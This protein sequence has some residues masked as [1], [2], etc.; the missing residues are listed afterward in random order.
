MSAKYFCDVCEAQMA[1]SDM[2]RI[3]RKLGDVEIEI[4]TAYRGCWNN[5]HLCPACILKAVTDGEPSKGL[6]E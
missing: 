6:T 4:M 3:K 5:G 1:A 2:K